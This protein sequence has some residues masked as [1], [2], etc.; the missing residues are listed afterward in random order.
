[1]ELIHGDG[2]TPSSVVDIVQRMQLCYYYVS[3]DTSP[4]ILL[5]VVQ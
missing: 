4:P 3:Y 2:E 5:L 1:M